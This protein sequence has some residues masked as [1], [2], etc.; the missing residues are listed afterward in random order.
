M[1]LILSYTIS[2]ERRARPKNFSCYFEL[3]Q[4]VLWRFLNAFFCKNSYQLKTIYFFEKNWSI[5]VRHYI[6][7]VLL[8]GLKRNTSW[9]VYRDFK[10]K[11][12]DLNI[13]NAYYKLKLQNCRWN[14]MEK[15]YLQSFVA[16]WWFF[17]KLWI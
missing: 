3:P 5:R 11:V 1:V 14:L 16:L 17:T 13:C 9:P 15:K 12:L 7:E 4:I 10:R 2:S 8:N 6:F